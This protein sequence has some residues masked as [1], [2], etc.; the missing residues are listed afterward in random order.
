[1]S[2][3]TLECEYREHA[4]KGVARKLR[5]QGRIPGI[6]YGSDLKPVMLSL[7]EKAVGTLL[8]RFGLNPIINL[9]IKGDKNGEQSY[10]CMIADY[11]RDVFQRKLLHLDLKK[12]DLNKPVHTTI[13]LHVHGVDA[14]RARG[15]ITEQRVDRINI[16]A[17]PLKIPPKAEIDISDKRPGAH[18]T[19][20]D[21]TLPE[22]VNL[23][24]EPT[25]V[26]VHIL[27]PRKAVAEA[28]ASEEATTE[29]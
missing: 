23:L 16:E 25:E 12:I 26:F 29:Q 11:Q 7:E 20:A 8:K 5:A 27:A 24:H 15:G 18:I 19:A 2:Q 4:G 28:A 13:P 22:G 3:V 9:T 6:L 1:M 21:I 17:L 14:V 10:I